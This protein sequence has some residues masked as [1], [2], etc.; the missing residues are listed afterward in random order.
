MVE[1]S[2]IDWGGHDNDIDYVI[3]ETLD[4]D[5]AI[6]AGLDFAE[7][8]NNT[9]VLVTADHETGGLALLD[10]SVENKKVTKVN[11]SSDHHTAVMVPIFAYGPQSSLFGGIHD[12]TFVGKQMIEFNK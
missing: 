4:F 1:G 7:E 9:L 2:Q 10:G 5:D 12:N 8:N 11:F 6:G 3:S